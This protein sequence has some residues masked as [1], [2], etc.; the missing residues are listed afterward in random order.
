[1]VHEQI[2]INLLPLLYY[3]G[4]GNYMLLATKK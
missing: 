3:N 4:D 1:M 2:P